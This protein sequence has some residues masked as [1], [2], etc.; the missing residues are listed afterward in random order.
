MEIKN[1]GSIT[2]VAF[3]ILFFISWTIFT[4]SFLLYEEFFILKDKKEMGEKENKEN[5]L[6][7]IF[8][9][10]IEN[11]ENFII[12]N[13][14][15]R[16]IIWYFMKKDNTLLW[17]N[18]YKNFVKSDNG[19][20]IEKIYIKNFIGNEKIYE[21]SKESSNFNFAGL[22]ENNSSLKKSNIV[23]IYFSKE[24]KNIFIEGESEKFNIK[25]S[26]EIFINYIFK[27]SFTEENII[28]CKIEGVK[29]EIY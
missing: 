15:T 22:I 19:Y 8:L 17:F 28:E 21:F 12:N 7:L 11:I 6:E 29:F 9:K 26:G 13:E 5:L 14:E 10:E 24:L 1:R 16:D 18:N 27:N 3:L 4:T 2:I 25:I 20:E 23:R